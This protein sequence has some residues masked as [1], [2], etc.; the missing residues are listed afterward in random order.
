MCT[1]VCVFV[2]AHVCTVCACALRSE[3]TLWE[4]VLSF[5]FLGPADQIQ[6]VSMSLWTLFS[7]FETEFPKD[8]E[9]GLVLGIWL[10]QPLRCWH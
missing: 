6:F 4:L 2:Q 3:D 9:A 10:P 7:I 1:T 8:A 5:Q